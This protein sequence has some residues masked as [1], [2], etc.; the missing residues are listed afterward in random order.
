MLTEFQHLSK[1]QVAQLVELIQKIV[2]AVHP[3]KVICYGARMNTTSQ[4]NSF[5]KDNK[6]MT[7]ERPAY[8]LLIIT[9]NDEKQLDHEIIESAE[10]QAAK[11]GCDVTSLVQSIGNANKSLENGNRF[12]STVYRNGVLLYDADKLPLSAPPAEP[13]IEV[14]IDTISN[15]WKKGFE[16]AQ[17][18]FKKA[19]YCNENAWYEQTTFDLHQAA[20]HACMCMLRMYSGYR[21]N[22]HNLSRLLSLIKN[23]SPAPS[24]VF[25]C[26]TKEEISIYN[27]LNKAY[28]D[29]RYNENYQVTAEKAQLLIG[30]VRAL[31]SIAQQLYQERLL[32]LKSDLA[33]QLPVSDLNVD[34]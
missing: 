6:Y 17:C 8:D 30:R 12:F 9:N 18:F 3:N 27:T 29:A 19:I 31:L 4:W 13:A 11:L 23:F 24:D 7:E 26:T 15:D 34:I 16:L 33:I 2:K 28:S 1:P 20:Q 32:C 22:T 14:L 21:S 10:I 5:M 25:P